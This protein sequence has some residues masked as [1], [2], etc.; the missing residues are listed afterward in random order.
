MK[1][2]SLRSSYN[3]S[4]TIPPFELRCL[5]TTRLEPVF[6]SLCDFELASNLGCSKDHTAQTDVGIMLDARDEISSY[7]D[8]S[9]DSYQNQN[10]D[11]IISKVIAEVDT[12]HSICSKI[13]LVED[14][15]ARDLEM[16][17][18]DR[19]QMIWCIR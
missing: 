14:G 19:K 16:L 17:F 3:V 7:L 5:P 11:R 2:D 9:C 10:S 4:R 8:R 18:K 6:V 1:I 12:L 15:Q 13:V